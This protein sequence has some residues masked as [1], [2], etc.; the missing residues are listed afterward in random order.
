MV[1][2]PHL[3]IDVLNIKVGCSN[4]LLCCLN[5]LLQGS[6]ELFKS[7]SSK[8]NDGRLQCLP[9]LLK[10]LKIMENATFLSK[11]NQVIYLSWFVAFVV[12]LI[13]SQRDSLM[14]IKK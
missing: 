3:K 6:V 2:L 11:E 1:D 10:C 8:S 9:M 14:F 12:M 4:C 7:S 5:C 13:R